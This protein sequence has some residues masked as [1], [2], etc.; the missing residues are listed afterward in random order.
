MTQVV[1]ILIDLKWGDCGKKKI[2][3][4]LLKNGDYTHSIRFSGGGN[5]GGSLYHNDEKVILHHLPAGIFFG[6]KSIIGP[7]C[8]LNPVKFFEEMSSLY[9]AGIKNIHDLVKISRNTHIVTF[10]NILEDER[11]SKIGTTKQGIGPA[12][13]DKYARIGLQAKDVPELQSYLV[14]FYDEIHDGKSKTIL[15]EG[16]Q[17]TFLDISIGEYPYVTSSHTTAAGALLSGIPHQWIRNIVGVCKSYDTYVGNK[18]G[19][20]NTNDSN[21]ERLQV[22]GKEIGAT[23]GRKRFCNYLD[24][25]S[26]IRAIQINGATHLIVNKMDI[27]KEV[28]VWKLF[29]MNNELYECSNEEEFKNIFIDAVQKNTNTTKEIKWSYNAAEI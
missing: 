22:V 19:F 8:V 16:A 20:Q 12:Y 24:L 1:D 29:N 10:D 4:N 18:I 11:D 14:D 21:L 2:C 9:D 3:Y 26:L 6:I 25:P 27:L 5:S 7:E 15:M 17:G 28:G 23:T 13:R